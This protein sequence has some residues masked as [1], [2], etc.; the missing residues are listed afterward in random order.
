MM[1]APATLFDKMWNAHVVSPFGD[2]S[3]VYI[4]RHFLQETTCYEAFARLREEGLPVHAPDRTFAVIDHCVS[5]ESGRTD[6]S[7]APT[8]YWI[9]AMR[10][11][12]AEF[13][14][15]LFDI[16]DARQGIV[17]VIAPELGI[18][19]P[20][21]SMVCGDSH[22]ATCGGLGAWAFG[23]GTSQVGQVLVSQ[24]LLLRKPRTMRVN[25]TGRRPPGVYAKD[26]ILGLIGK[27][28]TASGTGYAVEYAGEAIEALPIEGRMT[29]SNMSVEFGARAGF[30]RADERTF[31][32]LHGRPFAPKGAAWD[33]AVAHWRTLG[34]DEDAVFDKDLELDCSTLAPQ[35]SWGTSPQDMMRVD[36]QIPDPGAVSDPERRRTMEKA[37]F[38]MGLTPGQPIA[39]TPI[40]VAFIGSCTNGRLSD[41][42]EAARI[43]KGRRVKD[44]VRALVVPGST[45]VK[46]KAE[47][48]GLG[49]IFRDAGFE[50]REA[51]CSMCVSGNGDIVPPGKRSI[52]TTNRNFEGRQGP[53]SRTH[54]T[55]PAMVAAAAITGSITDVRKVV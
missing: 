47:A 28:G 18:A 54:I 24:A 16:T 4:D 36:A 10:K 1:A 55:S 7:F 29:I 48:L 34:S 31:N 9:R 53:D 6:E 5:T 39:G 13:G 30:V 46:A 50:W 23:I 11:N 45:A 12:C 37:L 26:M 17:H 15:D 38:Y 25:F 41:L 42:E 2:R 32:Y 44:G 27:Y 51:G 49:A 8:T 14:I 21:V 52:S 22:T 33:A 19:L 35:I 43:V 20:G 40:D 3:V